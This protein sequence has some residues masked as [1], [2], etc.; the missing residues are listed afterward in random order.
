MFP[1]PEKTPG[2]TPEEALDR[3][4]REAQARVE[5]YQNLRVELQDMTAT[6][7]SPDRGVS[8]TVR[9][10]GAVTDIVLNERAMRHGPQTLA[11]LIK[12][13]IQQATVEVNTRLAERTQ[14]FTGPGLDVMSMV[15]GRLPELDTPTDGPGRTTAGRHGH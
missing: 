2:E 9:P 15:Q 10:G 8:V 7:T 5:Q 4:R 12:A 1:P 6:A 13:A 11:N 14:E 3:V